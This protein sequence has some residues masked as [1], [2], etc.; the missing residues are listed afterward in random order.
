MDRPPTRLSVQV[1]APGG[2][3]NRWGLDEPSPADVPTSLA[4]SSTMPGGFE[5]FSCTLARRADR[6][7]PDLAEFSTV[8]VYGA[9]G[10]IAWQGRL[11]TTPR[12]SGDQL[13]ITPGAVGWQA[14]L[15]DE[16]NA[17]MIYIDCDLTKWQPT[18]VQRKLNV[19]SAWDE[20]DPTVVADQSTSAPALQTALTGAWARSSFSEAFYDAKAL[21]LGHLYYGWKIGSTVNS[22]DTNWQWVADLSNDAEQSAL[23]SSG[24][25]RAAGP[26][27][28]VVNASTQ[29]RTFAIVEQTYGAAAG[30]SQEVY[31]VFW[32]YLAVVGNHGL[33]IQG[34]LTATGGLGVLASDVIQ[35]AVGTWAPELAT[36]RNGI[37][38][39]QQSTFIIPQLSFPDPTTVSNIIAAATAYGLVDWWVDEGPTFNLAT[40]DNHGREWQ[41]RVGPSG[42]QETGPQVD[43]LYSAVV[44]SY[45]DVTGAARTVGPPGSGANTTDSSLADS[46]PSNPVNAAGLDRIYLMPNIGVSTPAGAIAVGQRFLLENAQRSTAG[47]AQIV[48]HVQDASGVWWPAWA[49]RAGDRIT[50]V[51]AHDPVPRRITRTQYSD[52]S[53]ACQLDLDSPPQ[54]IS[55]LLARY[56]I[57][58]TGLGV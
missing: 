28:G 53:R 33:P 25:L 16:Q 20:Q 35:H 36:S 32:T 30:S 18:T 44:V 4:F 57:A 42:L 56:S 47:Q 15:D 51:D 50:F 24:N 37:S 21:P 34:T 9:G 3:V 22:A 31:P 26:G 5:N 19:I 10:E 49:I 38:T 58:L 14:A 2:V 29:T 48:G 45:N 43:H 17:R 13:Q 55:Q 27:S 7:Y 39:I 54:D 23:D 52:S 41:A 46:D 12:T 11:E 40:P 1:Q 6:D 8:T